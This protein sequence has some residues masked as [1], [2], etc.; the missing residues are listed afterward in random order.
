MD[1]AL[2]F[3]LCAPFLL[4]PGSLAVDA[5]L[6]EPPSRPHPVRLMGCLA[7]FLERRLN[8]MANPAARKAAHSEESRDAASGEQSPVGE[9]HASSTE[10]KSSAGV[11]RAF[12]SG[13]GTHPDEAHVHG[14]GA[15]AS[16]SGAPSH[17][18]G[19][20]PCASSVPSPRALFLRGLL[21][22]ILVEAAFVLPVALAVLALGHLSPWAALLGSVSVLWLCVSMRSMAE[23][24]RAVLAPLRAGDLE[25]ARKRLSWIV[26]RETGE[27][28]EHGVARAAL[29]SVAENGC[30]GTQATLFWGGCGLFLGLAAGLLFNVEPAPGPCLA[31]ACALAV[32]HRV[33]NTLDAMWGHKSERFRHFGTAAA[34]LDDILAWPA[35]RTGFP[36]VCLAAAILPF[37]SGRKAFSMGLRYAPRHASPNAGWSEAAYAGALGLC[38]GGPCRYAGV[39]AYHA[40]LGEGRREVTVTDVERAIVLLRVSCLLHALLLALPPALLPVLAA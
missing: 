10:K 16:A 6:G 36:A 21:G 31:L 25:G 24:A 1:P 13:D 37:A 40:L 38:L 3:W 18:D 33:A 11:S 34:R 8:P 22:V 29:E 12:A 39:V 5:L 9:P 15:R 26:G 27:L 28:D 4:L 7:A 2:H 32:A 30:D 35:A 19:A 14:D 23:H 17:K 20:R